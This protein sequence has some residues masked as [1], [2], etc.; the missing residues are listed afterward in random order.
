M[1]VDHIIADPG[2][3]DHFQ[4]LECTHHLPGDGRRRHN[5]AIRIVCPL[6]HLRRIADEWQGLKMGWDARQGGLAI[7]IIAFAASLNDIDLILLLGHGCSVLAENFDA[8]E[9]LSEGHTSLLPKLGVVCSR[10]RLTLGTWTL[11]LAGVAVERVQLH[12][13][14]VSDIEKGVW[15]LRA[16]E[17]DFPDLMGLQSFLQMLRIR[18][19][20]TGI[21]ENRIQG[22][23]A[24]DLVVAVPDITAV[25]VYRDHGLRL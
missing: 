2:P 5:Q 7:R 14:R 24:A 18:Q 9:R 10:P 15:G 21:R 13:E 19:Q 20:I 1:D 23:T 4:V 22:H 11:H 8:L 12:S 16:P 25:G 17:I 3:D 6:D